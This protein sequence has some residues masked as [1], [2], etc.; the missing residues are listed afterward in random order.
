MRAKAGGQLE[1]S[2][3]VFRCWD[4]KRRIALEE[5]EGPD[6]KLAPGCRKHGPVFRPDDMM[7]PKRVPEH[8][9]G[10]LDG[11]IGAGPG[12]KAVTA[13]AL[14]G[15]RSR[16]IALLRIIR[17]HPKVIFGETRALLW[18]I[19]WAEQRNRIG[20]WLQLVADRITHRP[21]HVGVDDTPQRR[22]LDIDL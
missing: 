13:F 17:C 16:R 21:D 5:V 3:L 6:L 8:D 14:I 7:K 11:S 12:R 15:I 2:L 20:F 19:V 18:E 10:I 9:V 4:I 1:F 22:L